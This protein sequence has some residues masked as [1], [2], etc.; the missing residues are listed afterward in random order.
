VVNDQ[1]IQNAK[2]RFELVP[3]QYYESEQSICKLIFT[4]ATTGTAKYVEFTLAALEK[5]MQ[6][7][8]M[9]WSNGLRELDFM[10]LSTVGGFFSAL[11]AL[12]SGNTYYCVRSFQEEAVKFVEENSIEIL[13][14]TPVQ[15]SLFLEAVKKLNAKPSSLRFVKSAGSLAST[16]LISSVN[17]ILNVPLINVYGSTEGGGVTMRIA[18][19]DGFNVGYPLPG[20]EIQIVDESGNQVSSGLEGFIKYKTPQ[21]VSKYFMNEVETKRSFADGWFFPGDTG[22]ILYDG[23]LK[24]T[25]RSS[26]I[27]NLGGMKIDPNRIDDFTL[28]FSGVLDC[29]AVGF[30]DRFGLVNLALALVVSEDFDLNAL[31]KELLTNFAECTPSVYKTVESIPRNHMGKVIRQEVSKFFALPAEN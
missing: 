24:L 18:E 23:S 1:W 29:A 13:A 21:I 10:G 14:A 11:F 26:E 2:K 25:G 17:E 16:G 8:P 4:S 28:K 3:P 6:R 22:K 30:E 27:I 15:I 31:K 20:V 9:Y 19:N 5:R 7:L 12:Y